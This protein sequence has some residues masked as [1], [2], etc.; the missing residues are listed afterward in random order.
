MRFDGEPTNFSDWR[1]WYVLYGYRRKGMV[2]RYRCEYCG[3][4]SSNHDVMRPHWY[5]EHSN[6]QKAKAVERDTY[7][8]PD[9]VQQQPSDADLGM[10]L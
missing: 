7:G 8:V 3:F 4:E 1:E 6:G 2:P 5:H 9:E 10:N